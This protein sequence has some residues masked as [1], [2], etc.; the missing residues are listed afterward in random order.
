MFQKNNDKIHATMVNENPRRDSALLSLLKN[1]SHTS[2]IPHGR[3]S[4]S[5][6]I[7]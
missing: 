1:K 7:S 4:S 2:W 6:G 5:G 3:V